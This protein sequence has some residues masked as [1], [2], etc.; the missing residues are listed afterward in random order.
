MARNVVL[1]WRNVSY[2]T[3]S[4]DCAEM[5]ELTS[6]QITGILQVAD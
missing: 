4:R 3:I 5:N 2:S 1:L 6:A